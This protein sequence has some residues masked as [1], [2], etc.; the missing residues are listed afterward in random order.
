[1]EVTPLK[2]EF[3]IKTLHAHKNTDLAFCLFVVV[4][5]ED[6]DADDCDEHHSEAGLI[7]FDQ[8]ESHLNGSRGEQVENSFLLK[9][10]HTGKIHFN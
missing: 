9:R 3:L 2:T 4:D 1:M 8:I 6:D 5:P 10:D 7:S